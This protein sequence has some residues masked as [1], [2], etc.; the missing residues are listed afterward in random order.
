MGLASKGLRK[1]DK[2]VQLENIILYQG[3]QQR[4]GQPV[5]SLLYDFRPLIKKDKH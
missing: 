5:P 3:W 2:H 4:G 1:F